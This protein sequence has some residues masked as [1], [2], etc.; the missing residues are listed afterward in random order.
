LLA[1]EGRIRV[2]DG[3][4]VCVAVIFLNGQ[5]LNLVPGGIDVAA[6]ADHAAFMSFERFRIADLPLR[7]EIGI[8]HLA[9]PRDSSG[10]N[11][12]LGC[13]C[14]FLPGGRG[15]LLGK[16]RTAEE[17]YRCERSHNRSLHRNS[18]GEEFPVGRILCR[19]RAQPKFKIL[20]EK[21]QNTKGNIR[22][23]VFPAYP[24]VIWALTPIVR[25]IR[26]NGGEQAA[27]EK[28]DLVA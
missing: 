2:P 14:S 4:V 8:Q 7:V 15:L 1:P 18:P 23:I 25:R 27:K 6:D 5:N 12:H 24:G 28:H 22:R 26:V 19:N 11:Q 21:I 16:N 13:G 3:S 17:Q 9:I 20:M 10:N